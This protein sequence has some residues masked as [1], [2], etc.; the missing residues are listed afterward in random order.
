ML[1]LWHDAR[2]VPLHVGPEAWHVV[3]GERVCRFV[4]VASHPLGLQ[5]VVALDLSVREFLEFLE[6]AVHA[7][8]LVPV[9]PHD[10]DQG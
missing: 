3:F 5:V 6:D 7:L 8:V 4:V 9:L 10:F 1:C 2:S